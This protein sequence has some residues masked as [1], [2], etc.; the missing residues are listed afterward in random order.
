MVIQNEVTRRKLKVAI[1]C[2]PKTIDNDFHLI[3]MSFGFLTAV[4]QAQFAIKSAKVQFQNFFCEIP[5]L[6]N[7][8]QV[9]ASGAPNGIGLV[10]LMGRQS[11]FIATMGSYAL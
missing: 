8:L 2:V 11:G 9:E 3:D 10:K 5:N 7:F 6:T 1:A 4:D